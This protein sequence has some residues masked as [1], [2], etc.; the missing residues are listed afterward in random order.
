V[1][2]A[3]SYLLE[4]V[5]YIHRNPL[6]AGLA[7]TLNQYI[8]SS[9]KG[10]LSNAKKWDWLHKD[11]I[12]SLFSDNRPESIRLYRQFV[13]QKTPKEISE[14]FDKGVIPSVLG[15][16]KF[17]NNIKEMFFTRENFEEVPE[18][19]RLAP[20]VGGIKGEVCR[21][22][23]VNQSDLSESRR[24]Y[25]NEPRNIAIYLT[26]YLRSDSLKE[27]GEAFEIEKYSTVSSVI[28][29]VKREIVKDKNIKRRVEELSARLSKGQRQT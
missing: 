25:H 18:S 13:S 17:V 28:R 2:D 27:I 11:F 3:N 19:Q 1:V 26:R 6:E 8:W 15:S 29:R 10:Y 4:L 12:L 7:G 16:E 9:H 23:E 20:D 22:Y 5:R 21:L 14:T 24:G